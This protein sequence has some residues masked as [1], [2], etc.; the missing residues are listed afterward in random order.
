MTNSMLSFLLKS[1]PQPRSDTEIRNAVKQVVQEVTLTALGKTSFFEAAAFNGGTAL[2]IFHEL[3]RFSEDLD[4]SVDEPAASGFILNDYASTVDQY[5]LSVGI[6][7]HFQIDRD[8]GIVRRAYVK[9]NGREI[10]RAFGFDAAAAN[11]AANE[12][13]RVKIEA[14][15]TPLEAAETET[16]FLLKPYPSAVRVYTM[17]SMFAGKL[18]AVLCRQW[19]ARIKGRDLYDYV[20]YIANE[21]PVNLPHLQSRLIQ[22]GDWKPDAPLDLQ[23]VKDL[24]NKRFSEIDYAMARKDVLPFIGDPAS[25][26]VWSEAFFTAI[27]EQLEGE[28]R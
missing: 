13:I 27:T 12:M 28:N 6:P 17:P 15:T 25:L 23:T 11:T 1:Y 16:K 26:D 14:D 7:A 2:R 24:L 18:H 20:F 8:E 19:A 22:S 3:P 5:L 4:F 9:G 21:V 10:L